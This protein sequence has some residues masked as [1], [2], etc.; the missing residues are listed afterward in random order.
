[1]LSNTSDTDNIF[2]IV[3]PCDDQNSENGV[4]MEDDDMADSAYSQDPSHLTQELTTLQCT[5]P[6]FHMCNPQFLTL[7][8]YIQ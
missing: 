8:S 1:M 4:L 7:K 6:W 2:G 3:D 5:V